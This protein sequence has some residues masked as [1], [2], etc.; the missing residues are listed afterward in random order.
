MKFSVLMSV[1]R[2]ERAEYLRQSLQSLVD[3]T[4]PAD[5]V[6]LVVDG[7]VTGDLEGILES[8]R[9]L[10]PLKI[11]RLPVNRGLAAALNEGLPH[12]THDWVARMDTD[13][14]ALPERFARQIDFI[15]THPQV[16]VCGAWLEERDAAMAR[17][18]AVRQVPCGHDEILGFARRRN[19]ISHPVSCFRKSAVLAVGGYPLVGKAQD[20]ALWS[21][22]LV[23]GYRFA[24]LPEVLLWMRTG[25]DFI[26]RRGYGYFLGE[27]DLLRFQ[28]KIG[29]LGW[30]DFALNLSIRFV[31]RIVPRRLKQL[32]YRFAR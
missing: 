18:V 28:R 23:R 19:P 22:M 6:V 12:C 30:F 14:I 25:E 31:V 26:G 7:P 21:L 11:V 20:Y 3:Q 5:E 4:L 15:G 9:D 8:F 17:V 2:L 24:N 16:D 13:D 32:L 27:L 10:L 1:Y 29:F